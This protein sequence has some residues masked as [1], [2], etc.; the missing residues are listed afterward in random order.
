M[1]NCLI[2]ED[3]AL[4]AKV[5][6]TYLQPLTNYG[7]VGYAAT[8]VEAFNF[9]N[10]HKVDLIFLD[11]TMPLLNGLDFLKSLKNP[12]LIIITTAYREYAVEGFELNVLDYLV[13]PIPLP[14]FL[15]AL[16]KVQMQLNLSKTE[17]IDFPSF[18]AIDNQH[19]ILKVNKKHIRVGLSDIYYIESLKDYIR[20]KTKQGDYITH[21]TLTSITELLPND[22]FVRIHRSYTVSL[23]MVTALV[24]NAL[25]IQN[26]LIP[27]GR[28]FLPE[29][30][31]LIL[32]SGIHGS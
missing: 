13:K 6:E 20:I 31:D 8:A 21:Q 17:A 27:I 4:A 19:I 28:N 29:I 11:I 16:E 7:I 24:G 22:R 14:R 5:I 12:P 9:L 23:N 1:I 10:E 30:K 25:E 15:Q 32:N 18:S 3:E 2:V 26:K